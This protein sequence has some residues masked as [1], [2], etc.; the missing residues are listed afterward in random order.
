MVKSML[1]SSL[2]PWNVLKGTNMK[3]KLLSKTPD[4]KT[5]KSLKENY[6]TF[7]LYLDPRMKNICQWASPGCKE[8]CLFTAGR[9]IMK[10]VMSAR[11]R[12]TEWYLQNPIG[13]CAQL[14]NEL[15]D[16]RKWSRRTGK[17]FCVRLNG[18]SDL[19]FTSLI[20]THD[21]IQFYDYTKD[22]TKYLVTLK[23]PDLQNYHLTFSRSDS[24]VNRCSFLGEML[25]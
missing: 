9:G 8:G 2:K 7:I 4:A 17:R 6:T 23:N 5:K 12:K 22:I 13:F 10:N 25:P 11:R 19:D 15:N 14:H 18:T 24:F 21:D 20:Q 1:R 3:L 16:I